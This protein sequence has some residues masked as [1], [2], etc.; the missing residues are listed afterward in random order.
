[1]SNKL[2]AGMSL[3]AVASLILAACAPA[4]VPTP[5]TIVQTQIVA[6]TP[7]EVVVTATPPPPKAFAA[8]DPTTFV[9]AKFG[10][11]E[12]L[13]PALDYET[14]GAEILQSVYETLVFYNKENTNDFVPQLATEWKV[15]ADSKTYTFTIRKGVKFHNGDELTPEDVAYSFQRGLLQG[16][17]ASPQFL[18]VEPFFGI[19]MDDISLLVDPEGGLYDDAEKMKA[20]DPAKLK[21]ACEQVKSAIVADNA[22]GTVTMT[23]AQPWGPFLATIAQT[24]GSAMDKKWVVENKGWDGSC[25][26]WQNFYAVTSENDPFTPIANGTGPFKLDHWTPGQETVLVRNDA[27]WRTDAA[28]EGGPTGQSKL[29][30]VVFKKVDEWGTRLAML[31]AGDADTADVNRV[32]VAQADPLVGEI[33]KWNNDKGAFDPCEVKSDAPLRLWIG[34]PQVSRTDVFLNFKINVPE[35][36]NPL[37][38]S[39]QLDGNGIPSDFFADE[40]V[41]KAFNYCFDWDT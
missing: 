9:Y 19:G 38:G 20:A 32:D 2:W 35:G 1:M 39:G 4:A 24:W 27:Y 36:G 31:Q 13:D 41:R 34:F 16:G 29:G 10:E 12:T 23:L 11:A 30:R 28:W 37:V 5:Q 40:H 21:A 18:L 14:A 33:C 26:T 6:G 8:K 25:D 17:T 15:S 22:A 7:V 3:F